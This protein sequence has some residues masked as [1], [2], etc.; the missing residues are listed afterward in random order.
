MS[1]QLMNA[2]VAQAVQDDL[3]RELSSPV[4]QMRSRLAYERRLRRA[5][6]RPG[7]R[8]RLVRSLRRQHRIEEHELAA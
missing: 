4:G 1:H 6:R 5:S 2:A 8:E 3:V 7:L